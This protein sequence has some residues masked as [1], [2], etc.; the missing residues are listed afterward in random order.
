VTDLRLPFLCGRQGAH[1]PLRSASKRIRRPV[2]RPGRSGPL[3]GRGHRKTWKCFC[4]QVCNASDPGSHR[5]IASP[6][7]DG[8]MPGPVV[9]SDYHCLQEASRQLGVILFINGVLAPLSF[10]LSFI[11]A[12]GWWVILFWALSGER[13]GSRWDRSPPC[14]AASRLRRL[15]LRLRRNLLPLPPPAFSG[16]IS[17]SLSCPVAPLSRV[18]LPVQ[19]PPLPWAGT[20]AWGSQC[21]SRNSL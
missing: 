15:P 2:S 5:P 10:L 21:G 20:S 3:G 17:S 7:R 16:R 19:V 11:S 8:R 13:G 18:A 12:L 9:H 6:W 4:P 14:Q 1:V